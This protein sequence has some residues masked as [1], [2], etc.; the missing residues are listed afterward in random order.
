ME[1]GAAQVGV[2]VTGWVQRWWERRWRGGGEV[3]EEVVVCRRAWNG[4]G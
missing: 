2:G 1:G 3:A 4:A